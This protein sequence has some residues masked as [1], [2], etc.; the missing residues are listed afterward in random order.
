MVARFWR[1][2]VEHGK[3]AGSRNGSAISATEDAARR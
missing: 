3:D 1:A 2:R